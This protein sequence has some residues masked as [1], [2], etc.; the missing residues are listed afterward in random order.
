[1]MTFEER[2]KDK[3]EMLKVLKTMLTSRHFELKVNEMFMAGLIHGTTH[4]G[5]GEEA[6]HAGISLGLKEDDWIVPTHRGHGHCLAKGATPYNM[7]C[8]LFANYE[9]GCKGLGGSMH[10]IDLEHC[11]LGSSAIVGAGV[12]TAVGVAFALKKQG[13]KNCVAAFFGDGAS[14]QGMVLEGMN[15]ASIWDVPI[16]LCCEN[17]RY[18][19]STPAKF[20]VP[21]EDIA[22][23]G[24]GFN[25]KSKV[26]DGM[27]VLAVMEAVMEASEYCREEC[28]PYL[29]EFKTYRY[30]GH[31]KSDQRK[32]RTKDEEEDM[33][34]NHDAIERQKNYMIDQG[35]ITQEEFEELDK[36]IEK[37]IED[38]AEQAKK[39]SKIISVEEA[40]NYVYAE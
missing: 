7:F 10:Y 6:C 20:T 22:I 4:L 16:L 3:N 5:V 33:K 18:G 15:L 14:N 8:E 25:I 36:K 9:G 31:S 37:E 32:Y 28:K 30:L 39:V 24:E 26:V 27:D 35:M 12:P 40:M 38:A 2:K 19:M 11:N 13:K 17:N 21:V 1:M 23:R 29:L 34:K